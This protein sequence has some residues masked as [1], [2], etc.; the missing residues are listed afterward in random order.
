[1]EFFWA[2][3]R[4]LITF[5]LRIAFSWRRSSH[6]ARIVKLISLLLPFNRRWVRADDD[7]GYWIA[8]DIVKA[9]KEEIADRIAESDAVIMWIPGGGFRFDLSLLY[10]RT[11]ITWIRALEADKNIKCVIFVPKYRT[12]PDHQFPAAVDDVK[13]TCEWLTNVMQI[14]QSKLLLGGDD[15]GAAI[16][17]DL[18]YLHQAKFAGAIFASPY[19]GL[20][21]GGESWRANGD[22]DFFTAAAVDRMEESYIPEEGE[23]PFRYLPDRVDLAPSLPRRMLITVGG[24]EVLLD[25]AGLLAARARDGGVAVT[26]IQ[27]PDQVHLWSLL[28]DVL[29]EDAHVRQMAI[30]H[31]VGF[32][33]Q[34][35][36]SPKH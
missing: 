14:P 30:D 11:W 7:H 25:E 21:A 29:V 22:I 3:R 19:T 4:W 2:L 28:P 26:L 18:L 32:V 10:I 9:K 13:A 1:M 12:A 6:S 36:R 17:L 15:A 20:E 31:F 16:G 24:S 23:Q 34:C 27:S 5:L 8:E 33:E 35:V